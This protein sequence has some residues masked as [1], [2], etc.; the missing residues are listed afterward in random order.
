M[1]GGFR[2]RGGRIRRRLAPQEASILRS[3]AEGLGQTLRSASS[4]V[5]SSG[6]DR[7]HTGAQASDPVLD[8]LLPAA[9]DESELGASA[10][11]AGYT[12]D[13]I[14]AGKLDRVGVLLETLAEAQSASGSASADISVDLDHASAE[15]WLLVLADIRLAL[16][17]RIGTDRLS[18]PGIGAAG[19]IYDWLGWLQADLL[20]TMSGDS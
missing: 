2:R 3:L 19:D 7:Q 5:S 8:R 17:E 9:Y 16:A 20:E 10:E 1:I 11:F 13:R 6:R 12:R 4:E 14:V 15:A 18:D